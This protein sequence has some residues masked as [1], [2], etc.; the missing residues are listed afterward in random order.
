ATGVTV[1]TARASDGRKVGVTVNSFSSVS[2]DPPLIL[3]SLSRQTPSFIDFTNATHFA[4]NVLESQQHHLSRQ[5]STPLPDKFAGV[6]FEE[7]TGGVP[8]L[9]GA[10]AQLDRKSTR[11]NS[12]HDQISYA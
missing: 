12:S 7:G 4:V 5:F 9:H 6:E 8:L 11:L 10:I 3:W 1:V 2:L